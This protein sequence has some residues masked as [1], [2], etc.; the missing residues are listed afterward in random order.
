MDVTFAGK[1][2][3][4]AE[5]SAAS[6]VAQSR[7]GGGTVIQS[8][9]TSTLELSVQDLILGGGFL[10]GQTFRVEVASVD[11]FANQG[12]FSPMITFTLV[13]PPAPT[14]IRAVG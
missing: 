7:N 8:I 5:P 2:L 6:Y 13:S 11:A 14:N 3:W 1:I 12:T 9:A 10:P 4:D